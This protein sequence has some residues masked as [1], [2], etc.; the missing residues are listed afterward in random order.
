MFNFNVLMKKYT[1]LFINH[2]QI[3]TPILNK[4]N[5]M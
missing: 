2:L 5:P 1:H 3:N 4:G